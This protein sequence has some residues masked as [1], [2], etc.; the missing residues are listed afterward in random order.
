MNLFD[1]TRGIEC[2]L[3]NTPR[4]ANDA[5][6]AAYMEW[7]RERRGL[8]RMSDHSL[9]FADSP[10][11]RRFERGHCIGLTCGAVTEPAKAERLDCGRYVRTE[12]QYE[13]GSYSIVMPGHNAHKQTVTFDSL[14][15]AGEVQRTQTLPREP[16]KGGVI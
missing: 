7:Q 9:I 12:S 5:E 3:S 2:P 16:K 10:R 4:A 15:D 8:A 6:I 13:T 14:D 11:G 1:I